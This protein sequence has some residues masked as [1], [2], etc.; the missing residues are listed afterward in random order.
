MSPV[1]IIQYG[2]LRDR[3]DAIY[4]SQAFL[5]VEKDLDTLARNTGVKSIADLTKWVRKGIFYILKEE[6]V[7]DG[8]PFVRVA[9]IKRLTVG[10]DK[11]TYISTEK[12]NE[13]I[14][15]ELAPNDLLLSKSGTIGQVAILPNTH[16]KWNFSQDVIG[17][18]M[19]KGV[20]FR[21]VAAF[22]ASKLG[23][24][25]IMRIKSQIVQSHITLPFTRKLR[26]PIPPD[27]FETE[28]NSLVKES[29]EKGESSRNLL[30]ETAN[31]LLALVDIVLPDAWST[32]SRVS[33]YSTFKTSDNF[34]AEYHAPAYKEACDLITKSR[35][36]S[37][38]ICDI[39]KISNAK[40]Q[41]KDNPNNK[42]RYVS[43]SDVSG[44]T[45][46]IDTFTELL[47]HEA[48]S[49]ARMV[50]RAGDVIVSYLSGSADTSA[51]VPPEHDNS[52]G[53]TGFFVLKPKGLPSEVLLLLVRTIP[54][55]M[56]MYQKSTG[57]IMKSLSN[58]LFSN[59]QVPEVPKTLHQ[60]LIQNITTAMTDLQRSKF[61]LSH[62]ITRIDD[63]ILSETK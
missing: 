35:Y 33:D 7:D 61:L 56:Q 2:Q 19:K 31:K 42:I 17:L 9:D 22:L 37:R 3:M 12:H 58:D 4:Y 23:Q 36:G 46:T 28:I 1:S 41:P 47:G 54:F 38:R 51:I 10:K 14:K 59:L 24:L 50:L 26:I 32:G 53:S 45:G 40:V 15:T 6:Y 34:S 18:K 29:L 43:L 62:A 11:I 16:K 49:R 20:R 13:E 8:I 48:P 27:S 30:A 63:W 5:Q 44:S 57:S 39:A 60:D 52:I 21:Y 55:K 25:Q